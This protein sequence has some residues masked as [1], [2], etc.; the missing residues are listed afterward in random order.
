MKVGA[1]L[2]AAAV[3]VLLF[4]HFNYRV[5]G[6]YLLKS[7]GVAFLTAPF[8]GY[9]REVGSKPGDH[10]EAGA[11][12]LRMDT[13]ELAIEEANAIADQVRFQREAEKARATNGLA[14]M[15]ISMALAE[16]AK[17]RLDMARHRIAQSVIKAPFEGIV[18]EGDLRERIGAPIKQGDALFKIS[19]MEGIF[20]EAEINQRDVHELK[21]GSPGEVA[22]VTQPK[23]KYKIRV[24]RIY[25]AAFPKEGENV[26]I[27]RCALVDPPADWWRPGMSGLVK[28]EAG[29]RTLLWILTHRTVDFLRMWLWW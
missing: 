24:D 23:L 28:L 26:F 29:E 13:D 10:L 2:G 4:G 12:L 15:R 6:N 27:V 11:V 3:G 1:L 21:L 9:I 8:D 22:F 16:Q 19:K 7:E 14:E 17:A 20:V 18:I 25:P 5:E